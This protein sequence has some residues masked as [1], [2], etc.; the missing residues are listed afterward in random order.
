MDVTDKSWR[1]SHIAAGKKAS[2]KIWMKR[3]SLRCTSA[4]VSSCKGEEAK[5][6]VRT[7]G[8]ESM[9]KATAHTWAFTAE[10]FQS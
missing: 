9:C 4:L 6:K 1:K 10:L 5:A 2:V 8:E 3:C 7:R